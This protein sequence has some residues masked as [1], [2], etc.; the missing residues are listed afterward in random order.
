MKWWLPNC[1]FHFIFRQSGLEKALSEKDS[2]IARF[3]VDG[4]KSQSEIEELEQLR[5]SRNKLNEQLKAEV[6]E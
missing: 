1:E 6:C 5:L 4:V 3:E 2:S